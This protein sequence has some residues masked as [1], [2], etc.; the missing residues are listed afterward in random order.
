MEMKGTFSVVLV[1]PKYDG[2]IGS[3]ARAMRNFGFRD[4]ALVKPPEIGSEG[5]RNSMHAREL[6][7]DARV[8]GSFDEMKED[9]D[10]LVGTTAK[11]AGDGNTLRTPVFPEELSVALDSK[12][13]VGLLFGREDYG[14]L[15][16]EIRECDMLVTIPANPEYPTMNLAMS[17]AVILYELSKQANKR[18][19]SQKKFKE[20]S[21]KEKEILLRFFDE[22]VDEIYDR[23]YENQL[24]KKT[25][26]QLVGRAF[27][28]GR[29]SKTLT[30]LFRKSGERIRGER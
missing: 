21:G 28:S 22:L 11:V 7:E 15:N 10:F 27:I 3:V 1:E 5:R 4:L 18:R 6:M 29:E 26:R 14:L 24:S 9:F 23:D 2:N 8:Y 13:R 19:S 30:G 20:L 25:F 16:E 17:V 12:G